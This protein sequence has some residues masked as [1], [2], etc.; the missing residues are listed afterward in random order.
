[1]AHEVSTDGRY[2]K[3]YSSFL[4]GSRVAY[5]SLFLHNYIDDATDRTWDSGIAVQNLTTQQ[6]QIVLYYYNDTGS[7][8]GTSQPPPIPGRGIGVFFAPVSGFIGSVVV[9][10]TQNIAAVVNVS[11]DAPTGDTHG[12][13]NASSR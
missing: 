13:Y 3:A 7:I 1:M 5:G 8:A 12:M 2:A 6:A 9:T 11:N 4:S 10:S